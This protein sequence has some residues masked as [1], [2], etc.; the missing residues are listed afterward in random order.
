MTYRGLGALLSVAL[1]LVVARP[2]AGQEAA[3]EVTFARDVAPILYRHCVSCHREGAIG[4]FPLL[5]YQDA[6]PWARGSSG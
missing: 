3:A 6:R 2:A 1:G 5:S 4:G